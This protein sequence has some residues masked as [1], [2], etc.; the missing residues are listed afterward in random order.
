MPANSESE[1]AGDPA[2]N[3]RCPSGSSA[4]SAV[5]ALVQPPLERKSIPLQLRPRER[6]KATPTLRLT[7]A[8]APEVHVR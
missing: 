1:A 7:C 8:S 6:V 4:I 5:P 2:D 3:N